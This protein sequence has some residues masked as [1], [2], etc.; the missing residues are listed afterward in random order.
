MGSEMC[1]RDRTGI[2]RE[3]RSRQTALQGRVDSMDGVPE[4]G[5]ARWNSGNIESDTSTGEDE[6]PQYHQ[7]DGTAKPQHTSKTKKRQRGLAGSSKWEKPQDCRR[8][9]HRYGFIFIV[10]ILIS[11]HFFV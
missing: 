9:V 3:V 8:R 4:S 7:A 11:S 5:G 1:I 10:Q 2:V 6:A